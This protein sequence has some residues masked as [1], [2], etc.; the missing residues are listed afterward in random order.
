MALVLL[1]IYPQ[2]VCTCI[3]FKNRKLKN[4]RPHLA[5]GSLPARN[6]AQVSQREVDQDSATSSLPATMRPLKPTVYDRWDRDP[7]YGLPQQPLQGS[8]TCTTRKTYN[9]MTRAKT[10]QHN[11]VLQKSAP[12]LALGWRITSPH[13]KT[14]YIRSVPKPGSSKQS[15]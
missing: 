13:R 3:K 4:S 6:N 8:Y 15:W 5:S 2:A 14:I 7:R 10:W 11:Y 1:T 9:G 12:H